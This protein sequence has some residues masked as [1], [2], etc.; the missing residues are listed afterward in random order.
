MEGKWIDA[1]PV[2]NAILLNSGQLLEYWTGGRFHAAVRTTPKNDESE[3]ITI[4]VR[5]QDASSTDQN[6]QTNCAEST[7]TK[8]RLLCESRW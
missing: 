8:F 6:E 7:T 4:S 2:E 1:S 3:L 5:I